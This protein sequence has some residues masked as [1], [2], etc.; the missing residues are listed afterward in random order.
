MSK[1]EPKKEYNK[2][3][4]IYGPNSTMHCFLCSRTCKER[5]EDFK[6]RGIKVTFINVSEKYEKSKEK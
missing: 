2:A 4:C 6:E 5:Y 1:K 3:Q